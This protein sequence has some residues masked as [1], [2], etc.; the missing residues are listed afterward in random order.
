M[1][2]SLV[3]K[4]GIEHPL[5][6]VRRNAGAGVADRD[7]HVIAGDDVGI[8]AGIAVVEEDVAGLQHQRAAVRHGVARVQREIEDRGGKLARVDQRRPGI[9]GE[10]RHDGDLLAERRVQQLGGLERQRIDVDLARLERLLAGEGEQVLGQLRA[11]LGGVVDQLGD[12]GELGTVGD[13]IRQD[14]DRAG[15]DGQHIV[16]IVGDA[17][18]QLADGVHLLDLPELRLGGL[19]LGEVA[20][21]EEMAL[22]RLR[23]G[24]HP[25]QRD[26]VTV[27]VVVARLEAALDRATPRRAHL[28]ARLLEVI[29]VNELD[30]AVPDHVLRLV[31]RECPSRSG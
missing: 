6:Q 1:P 24:A 3:V 27:V 13:R 25:V 10:L 16:E 19:L 9:L 23:P 26:L 29:G 31:R 15:D 20:A 30:G 2:T 7:H 14:A 17:A 11:A 21:D 18:G 28:A 4:N 22:H 8:H 12:G 5:D